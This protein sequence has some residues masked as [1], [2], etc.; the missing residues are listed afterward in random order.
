MPNL[1]SEK[2][3]S[4][5]AKRVRPGLDFLT[6]ALIC[7]AS[8]VFFSSRMRVVKWPAFL[9]IAMMSV[10]PE[11]GGGGDAAGAAAAGDTAGDVAGGAAGGTAGAA[12]GDAAVVQWNKKIKK[13]REGKRTCFIMNFGISCSVCV[14]VWPNLLQG[15]VRKGVILQGG[16]LGL[17]SVSHIYTVKG[18]MG[19]LS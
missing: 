14:C 1:R 11:D 12:A 17:G 4:V 19:K 18:K 15:E 5:G 8:S 2:A 6:C 7:S 10:G 3:L 13:R 16:E 9:R